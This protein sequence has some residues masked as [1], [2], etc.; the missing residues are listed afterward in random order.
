[1][2]VV[3]VGDRPFTEQRRFVIVLPAAGAAL[4]LVAAVLPGSPGYLRPASWVAVA[5]GLVDVV[6][7]ATVNPYRRWLPYVCCMLGTVALTVALAGAAPGR[8]ADAYLI[9]F[10]W[11]ASYAG[12]FLSLRATMVTAACISAAVVLGMAAHGDLSAAAVP[13]VSS[14]LGVLGSALLVQLFF[15]WGRRQMYSDPLTA[16]A[17]RAGLMQHAEPAVAEAL[18]AGREVVF[19]LLDVNRFRE[20]NDALGHEAGDEL[21]RIIARQLR[22]VTP[23]PLFLSRLGSDEFAIVMRGEGPAGES[24]AADERLRGLGRTVLTQ[25]RGPY[26]VNGVDVE[27]EASA[28]L[29]VAPRDGDS[30]AALLPCADA[31]LSKAKREGERVGLWEAGIAGVRP[32]EIALHAQLRNAIAGDE[33]VLY[34]Q[35]LQSAAT[36][37]ISGV[38]ALLRWRHP[39]RGLLPPGSFLPMAERSALIVD[40]TQ[41]AL[42]EALRQSAD[43]AAAGLHVPVSVNLSARMLIMDDLPRLVRRTLCNHGLPADVLT[44]EVTESALVTQPAR[45]AAMLRDLRSHGVNLSLDDFG[46]GYSSIEILKTLPFDEVKIDKGFVSG[47]RGSLPDAAIVRSVLDLGHRLGLRVVGEGVED[48]RTLR[49]MTEL[50][51]DI[52]QGDALSPPLPADELHDFLAS[53]RASRAAHPA[54]PEPAEPRYS[55]GEGEAPHPEVAVAGEEGAGAADGELFRPEGAALARW[56]EDTITAPIPPDE[57]ARLAALRRYGVLDTGREAAFDE[58]ATLAAHVC[59]CRYGMVIFVDAHR[60]WFKAMHGLEFPPLPRVAPASYVVATGEP[61]EVPDLVQDVRFAHM[62]QA[63]PRHTVRF[64][65]GAPLLTPDG[66]T[67]GAL[68][69]SD[70]TPR[71]LT[72]GQRAGLANLAKQAM[73]LLESRR[74]TAMLGQVTDG[75][76][77]L[78][79]LWSADDLPVA[80]SLIADVSRVL[81]G[82]SGV[83]VLLSDLPGA[84]I[85]RPV[86]SSTDAGTAPLT[87]SHLRCAVWDDAGIGAVLRTQAP[88]FFPAAAASRL[89]PPGVVD[90]LA[91]ASVLLVPLPGEGGTIGMIT[92]WWAT[93]LSR[94]D[95]ATQRAIALFGGQA[96]HALARLRIAAAKAREGGIDPAVART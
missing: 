38:E 19:M 90:R 50:G 43:W 13:V 73:R 74:E 83:T 70:R 41:W 16:L 94:L 36:G 28:G 78:D 75:L 21:L 8:G 72:P 44:L 20:V 88:V 71:R 42:N 32:W 53:G 91:I 79:Q 47:A 93:P 56:R 95:D 58:L 24:L 76:R 60:E 39:T 54:R 9:W 81:L 82:A 30:L 14:V 65:A 26:R 23:D 92:A 51:C 63:D 89:F 86:V 46:T 77:V 10:A 40:V 67:I 48:Q 45:A 6:L 96:A 27:V 85:F 18:A 15:R 57:P 1:V 34:Y 7:A 55:P 17:N 33:L 22:S 11:V 5:V 68:C 84:T 66:H 2:R 4:F 62:A 69:V 49:M 35:P 31:A 3:V 64:I 61:I 25:I 12:L 87:A 52:L 80:V 59:D 37:R 29:A